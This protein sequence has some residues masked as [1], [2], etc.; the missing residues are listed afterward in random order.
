MCYIFGC[1]QRLIV[2]F[3]EKSTSVST[4]GLS[5]ADSSEAVTGWSRPNF[6]EIHDSCNETNT[7]MLNA[8]FEDT[9]RAIDVIRNR[10]L[11]YGVEDKFCKKWFGNVSIFTVLGVFS[12]LVES[13]KEGM[14]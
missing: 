2:A 7:N 1:C 11:E 5:D 13:S 6:P 14:I 4:S 3:F 12:H 8:V 10:L 9:V